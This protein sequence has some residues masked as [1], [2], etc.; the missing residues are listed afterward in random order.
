MMLLQTV[1]QDLRYGARML[2]RNAGF[3]TVAV[4]ALA[5]GI[6]INTAAFTAYKAMIARSLDARDPGSMV[7]MALIHIGRANV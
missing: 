2:L 4:L 1:L 3:T 5:M 7:N 6:G